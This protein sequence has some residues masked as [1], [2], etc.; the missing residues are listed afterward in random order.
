MKEK[1]IELLSRINDTPN[2]VRS[3]DLEID[4]NIFI[5][6]KFIN[7]L[8]RDVINELNNLRLKKEVIK[9]RPKEIKVNKYELKDSEISVQVNTQEQYE[10]AKSFGIKHIY[11][12]NIIRRNNENEPE[13]VDNNELLIGG[14]GSLEKYKDS[15]IN[16]VTDYSFNVSNYLDVALLSN[17]GAKRITLSLELSKDQ[18]NNLVNNYFV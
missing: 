15:N 11:F 7:E 9:I 1:I 17:L 2:K 16:L 12:K 8:K 4:D 13:I 3:I 10:V 14:Y 5:P 6:V 18:I